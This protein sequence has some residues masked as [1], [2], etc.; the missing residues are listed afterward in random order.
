[1]LRPSLVLY[2]ADNRVLPDS[3]QSSFVEVTAG[4]A[5]ALARGVIL[6]VRSGSPRPVLFAACADYAATVSGLPAAMEGSQATCWVTTTCSQRSSAAAQAV[7]AC[8]RAS[9]LCSRVVR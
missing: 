3:V 2:L 5:H 4:A 6:E 1:M 9:R 7:R 8:C